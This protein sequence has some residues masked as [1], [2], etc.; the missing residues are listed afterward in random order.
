MKYVAVVAM[1]KYF[2]RRA[3]DNPSFKHFE[4]TTEDQEIAN[5][6]WTD[7]KMIVAYVRFGDVVVFDTTFGTN[8]EKWAFGV[9]VGFN[10]FREIVIFGAALMC[11]QTKD[12]FEWVFTKFLKAHG[13][14][15]PIT[16]FTDLDIAMAA[17]LEKIMSNTRHDLCVW[18]ISQNCLKYLSRYNKDG[19][20]IT[21]EFLACV[22]RYFFALKF[23]SI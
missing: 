5:I 15:K 8:N 3:L 20:N 7:G 10:H 19:I 17:A 1:T 13:G 11:D 21:G 2:A 9:F 23:L 12:S 4:D 18:H 16:I 22:F 14:K 6:V